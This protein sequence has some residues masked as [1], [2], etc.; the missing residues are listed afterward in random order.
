MK[1]A[2]YL[3]AFLGCLV[4]SSSVKGSEA[5]LDCETANNVLVAG[6]V[7]HPE[8]AP[9]LF[10]DDLRTNP[11]CRRDLV[12]LGIQFADEDPEMLK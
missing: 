5:A 11:G 8:Q 4:I 1:L 7:A 2:S 9:M 3:A 12:R 10:L 6:L